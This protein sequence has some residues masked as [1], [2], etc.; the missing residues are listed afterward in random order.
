MQH[1]VRRLQGQGL[2]ATMVQLQ[3]VNDAMHAH[4]YGKHN[5]EGVKTSFRRLSGCKRKGG[6]V[7]P[8][9][10]F[11]VVHSPSNSSSRTCASSHFW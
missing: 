6:E 11:H 8:P 2:G 4:S 7:P 9:F 10:A 1:R 5:C 3:S